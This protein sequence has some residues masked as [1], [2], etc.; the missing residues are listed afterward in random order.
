MFTA[1]MV[2]WK[3]Q[4]LCSKFKSSRSGYPVLLPFIAKHQAGAGATVQRI[5]KSRLAVH[6]FLPVYRN[7]ELQM[8]VCCFEVFKL[9]HRA[10]K[11]PVCSHPKTESQNPL[12]FLKS[13]STLKVNWVYKTKFEILVI[14]TKTKATESY[15]HKEEELEPTGPL[16]SLWHFLP[17]IKI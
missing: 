7:W 12:G 15:E 13:L 1:G 9:S 6:C 14:K 8:E 2:K 17:K 3:S 4:Q 11:R 16:V 5:L 10:Q